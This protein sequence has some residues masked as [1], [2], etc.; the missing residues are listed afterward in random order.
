MRSVFNRRWGFPLIGVLVL[1]CV[2][3]L[4]SGRRAT[5]PHTTRK[6]SMTRWCWGVALL[7]M[8]EMMAVPLTGISNQNN[9]V[10]KGE[11]SQADYRFSCRRVDRPQGRPVRQLVGPIS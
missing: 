4:T 6:A 9:R 10:R 1:L 8:A 11:D 5:S 3:P 7:E 2:R